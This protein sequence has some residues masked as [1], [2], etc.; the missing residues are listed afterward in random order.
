MKLRCAAGGEQGGDVAGVEFGEPFG[1]PV[2]LAGAQQ[3]GGE[4]GEVVDVFAGVVEVDDL[5]GGGEQLIGEVPDPHGAVA[6]DDELADVLSAAAAGFGVRELGEPGGGFEGG[7]VAGG[8]RVADRAAVVV[9]LAWVNRQASLTSRVWARPSSPL[10]G[11]PSVSAVVIG[12]PVP[13]TAM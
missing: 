6:E 13:S 11:R 7:Q 1:E 8:A 5:G 12:T 4:G 9:G 2:W 3:P 10:P